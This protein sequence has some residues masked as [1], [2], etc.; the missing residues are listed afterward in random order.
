MSEC[1]SA[2]CG[3]VI[4][5][6]LDKI[7]REEK[8]EQKR[9]KKQESA[10]EKQKRLNSVTQQRALFKHK[11]ALKKEILKK[12]ASMEKTLQQEIFVSSAFIVAKTGWPSK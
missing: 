8:Q 11:E 12:R 5:G 3:M 2:V 10:E 4:K 1:R 6:M 9:Q 7:E